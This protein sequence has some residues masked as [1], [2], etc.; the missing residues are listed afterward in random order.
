M[1]FA[2]IFFI[3]IK[4]INSNITI[5]IVFNVCFRVPIIVVHCC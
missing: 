4:F 5:Y 1:N 3:V 2:M